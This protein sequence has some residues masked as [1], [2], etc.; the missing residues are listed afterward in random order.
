MFLIVQIFEAERPCRVSGVD[1]ID[2]SSDAEI[3]AALFL[4]DVLGLPGALTPLGSPLSSALHRAFICL[5]FLCANWGNSKGE[6]LGE[7]F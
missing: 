7:N 1:E 6:M 4:S 5:V 3:T 2:Q